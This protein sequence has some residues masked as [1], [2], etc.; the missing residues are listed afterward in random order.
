[1][2]PST[3]LMTS[4]GAMLTLATPVLAQETQWF[5]IRT[6]NDCLF[7]RDYLVPGQTFAWSG[8]CAP[9]APIS[10]AGVLESRT[11]PDADGFFI[12]ER[13]RGTMQGGYWHGP[14]SISRFESLGGE[15]WP[16]GERQSQ[17]NMGCPVTMQ[18]CTPGVVM[19]AADAE[20]I[21]SDN[22][23]VP[24]RLTNDSEPGP[25]GIESANPPESGM[26]VAFLHPHTGRP[27]VTLTR[28]E[29]RNESNERRHRVV[30]VLHFQNICDAT[31]SISARRIAL[32]EQTNDPDGISGNGIDPAPSEATVVRITCIE[33]G[34]RNACL[35]FS[36]WW[37][38]GGGQRTDAFPV[39]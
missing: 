32:G 25:D 13:E 23:P 15:S 12:L 19:A 2:R 9:G 14:V 37:V 6:A 27:C 33:E 1:M 20:E 26:P 39:G 16:A 34:E 35:G 28:V 30:H 24:N 5:E 10:G 29:A 31:F 11:A 21:A 22:G 17:Y 36:E 8:S 7:Y 4:F 38:R 18:A 3:L